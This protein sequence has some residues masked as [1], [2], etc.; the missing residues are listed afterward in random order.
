[1]TPL[2]PLNP[3]SKNLLDDFFN[4]NNYFPPPQIPSTIQFTTASPASPNLNMDALDEMFGMKKVSNSQTEPKVND[5]ESENDNLQQQRVGEAIPTRNEAALKDLESH[6]KKSFSELFQTDPVFQ[7]NIIA[8]INRNDDSSAQKNYNYVINILASKLKDKIEMF[9]AR[10][11]AGDDDVQVTIDPL[12]ES[13]DIRKKRSPSKFTN[14]E[15]WNL[16]EDALDTLDHFDS[17]DKKRILLNIL[18]ISNGTTTYKIEVT[19][20]NSHCQEN[21]HETG[22]CN[23]KIDLD[24]MKMCLLEVIILSLL[25]CVIFRAW[26]QSFHNINFLTAN[27]VLFKDSAELF[28]AFVLQIG[29][30]DG[31]LTNSQCAPLKRERRQLGV[32]GG[33]SAIDVNDEDVKLYLNEALAEVNAG[34]DPDYT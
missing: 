17:D 23:E 16:A 24:S 14:K 26:A 22:K 1:M 5:D 12:S 20:A 29:E 21:S 9:N 15:F 32:P 13:G 34:E 2:A 33:V 18:M 25:S 3:S 30:A 10:Q 4:M 31:E 28:M 7:M 6:I 8:L 19:I 11:H 27:F